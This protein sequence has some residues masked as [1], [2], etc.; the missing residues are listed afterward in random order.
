VEKTSH[1]I[2][3]KVAKDKARTLFRH[4]VVTSNGAIV[5]LAVEKDESRKTNRNVDGNTL[6]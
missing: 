1:I 2:I 6:A 5:E 4:F 3:Y